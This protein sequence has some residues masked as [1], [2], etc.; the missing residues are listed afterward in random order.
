MSFFDELKRRNVFRVG[1]AYGVAAWLLIQ[2]NVFR[3]GIAYGVAAWLLIQISDTVFPRIGLSDS[4]VT[5]VIALLVIGFVPALIFAWAFEMTS[6]GLKREK[7]VDR[8]E[9]ITPK[10]GK[11]LDRMI[12][13]I[14]AVVIAFLLVDRFVLQDRAAA[15]PTAAPASAAVEPTP[16]EL[17]V[18]DA[19]VA[20]LP[21]VNMSG[22]ANNEYFS[23]GL[24]ETLLHMLAQLPE[25]R[26]AART[27][28]FAF[29]GQNK[30][31][32]EIA[33]A[34]KVANVLE[35]SVQRAGDRIRVTAQLIRA[36]DGYHVWSQ[37]Y[38]RTL[39]DIFAIQDEIANDVA[40]A[41]GASLL[42]AISQPM[43]GV[44]TQ[45]AAAYE[46]YLKG[47]EQQKI[48]SY[49]SLP[50][51]EGHFKDALAR[52]PGFAEAKLALARNYGLKLNTG[53]I[54]HEEATA[55]ALPL[56][57]Q[58]KEQNPREPLA[59]ALELALVTDFQYTTLQA[60][61]RHE[62]LAEMRALLPYIPDDTW[63]RAR[64]ASNLIF[65][66]NRPE[67][68]LEV[69]QAGL[70]SDPL[71]ADLYSDAARAYRR[72]ERYDDALEALQ[73]AME[74]EPEN[75]NPLSQVGDI[76]ADLGKLP[77]ALNWYRRATEADPR[78]HEL[79]ANLAFWF[80]ELE[81]PEEGDRWASRC[82]AMA[83]QT[84]VCKRIQLQQA[85]VSGDEERRMQL[86]RQMLEEDISTR[87]FGFAAALF[88]FA[89]MMQK[90]GRAREAYDFLA[91][92]YP[93][94]LTPEIP[95]QDLKESLV[96]RAGVELMLAF[97]P[98]EEAVEAMELWVRHWE[99]STQN[100]YDEWDQRMWIHLVKGELEQAAEIA[101]NDD[102]SRP[103]SD[104]I[105]WKSR[106]RDDPMRRVLADIPEVAA[107]LREL[108][109]DMAS[110]QGEVRQM[111]QEP[112]WNP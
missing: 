91:Q 77:E 6:E 64:V 105:R 32:E 53:L 59:R 51:A 79:V 28:S 71:A 13:G 38:D 46:Q 34:L 85:R 78:D 80:Y 72:M 36:D 67:E 82:Y 73:R 40:Q 89:D 37:N 111:L 50:I 24:T 70:L 9:S 16:A 99:E 83:P 14:M 75:P 110:L 26:V 55:A 84:A 87:R 103:L 41:L 63:V 112:E 102:L 98:R 33:A 3:V 29:K 30:G 93:S 22:D 109:M 23:D 27:S 5:L 49:S 25:L 2:R 8:S 106:Y 61:K 58:V 52:D 19:S 4:A 95:P 94:L 11:K 74:L 96:G 21:F 35:G 76:H 12:I 31:I 65:G 97:A 15:G 47:M 10:T 54:E 48:F 7:D 57:Q 100:T 39:N 56:L 17:E 108:D 18:T 86:T 45:N 66:Q 104:N 20:V 60:E 68:A 1:I 62:A 90:Q 81:M 101:L 69:I 107:R 42:G 92:K 44:S 43:H 88:S